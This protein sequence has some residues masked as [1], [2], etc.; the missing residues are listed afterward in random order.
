[1]KSMLLKA[2]ELQ[3][4]LDTQEVTKRLVIRDVDETAEF[5]RLERDPYMTAIS[6][7]GEEYPKKVKGLYACFSSDINDYPL[8]KM[9]YEPGEVI[10]VRRL[11]EMPCERSV[12]Y[13][14][15]YN[16]RDSAKWRSCTQEPFTPGRLFLRVKDIKVERLQDITGEE[17]LRSGV[18]SERPYIQ[19][20]RVGQLEAYARKQYAK[21]WDAGLDSLARA[22]RGWDANPWVT[23]VLLERTKNEEALKETK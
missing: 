17:A 4:V 6:R 13:G 10:Y 5:L 20:E 1:M 11:W 15:D 12:Y 9:P 14:S 7:S 22:E 8:F 21:Q 19:Y 16:Y 3:S 2:R 18:L 23:V